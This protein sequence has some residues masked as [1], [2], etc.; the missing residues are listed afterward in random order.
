MQLANN[1]YLSSSNYADTYSL[2]YD[3]VFATTRDPVLYIIESYL[4]ELCTS[5]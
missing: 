4:I 1:L 2:L 5:I 3:R